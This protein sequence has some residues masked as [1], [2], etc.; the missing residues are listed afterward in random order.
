METSPAERLYDAAARCSAD[1]YWANSTRLIETATQAL[2]DGLDSPGLRELAAASHSARI[3][4]LRR[5]LLDALDELSI[6]R[7]EAS[8]GQHVS[9]TRYARLPTDTLRFEIK[10]SG[11]VLIYVNDL[12]ITEAG[13][14]MGMHPFNLFVPSNQLVATAEPRHVV[15]ARCTCGE[16][17]CGSTEARITRIGSVVHWDWYVDPPLGHG[18]SFEAAQ[19]DAE[20]ERIGNDRSW[21]RPVDSVTRLVIEAVDR[22][23]W[24]IPGG[25]ELS[26]AGVDHRDP[27]QFLVA[28][29]VKDEQFQVFLR[30]PIGDQAPEQLADDVLRTL[31]QPPRTWRATFHSL[32]VGRRGRPSMAGW[33]WRSEDPWG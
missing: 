7:P 8:P 13:A 30:F 29:F 12:E 15:V 9:G 4:K 25:L 26:W 3:R 17:G 28:L 19:Y 5:L 6:P 18:M 1:P 23:R 14:G 2:V 21:Q 32:T 10:P 27:Q 20:V 24:F 11:E 33:R 22:E 16:S 31:R